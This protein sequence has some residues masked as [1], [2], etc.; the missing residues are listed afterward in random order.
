MQVYCSAVT[1]ISKAGPKLALDSLCHSGVCGVPHVY[2]C[3]DVGIRLRYRYFNKTKLQQKRDKCKRTSWAT[4]FSFELQVVS[5]DLS[6]TASGEPNSSLKVNW[7]RN[8]L[9]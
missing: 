1:A 7:R 5:R 9:V 6:I 8:T 2:C 4:V 3:R